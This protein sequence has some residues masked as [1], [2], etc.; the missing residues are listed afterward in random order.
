MSLKLH[1]YV[2]I[3]ETKNDD[4]KVTAATTIK[5]AKIFADG[6]VDAREEILMHD[7]ALIE[8]HGG[9]KAVRIEIRPFLN[10]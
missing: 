7:A 2:L 9:R 8:T 6:V 5:E 3:D 4:G 10:R 1:E